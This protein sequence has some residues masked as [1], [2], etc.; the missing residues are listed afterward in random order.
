MKAQYGINETA[1]LMGDIAKDIQQSINTGLGQLASEVDIPTEGLGVYKGT[2]KESWKVTPKENSVLIESSAPHASAI[3]YGRR[4]GAA[5]GGAMIEALTA[6]VRAKI[7]SGSDARSIAW[8][9]AFAIRAR[10]LWQPAGM[11]LLEKAHGTIAERAALN[12]AKLIDRGG[13]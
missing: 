6:W 9:I 2:Y 5:I 3:E 11:R 12:I 8:A 4:P 1:A 7:K 10:G 13:T